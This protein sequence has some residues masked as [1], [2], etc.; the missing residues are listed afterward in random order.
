MKLS[1]SII[2]LLSILFLISVASPSTIDTITDSIIFTHVNTTNIN[3]VEANPTSWNTISTLPCARNASY[4]YLILINISLANY[5]ACNGSTGNVDYAGTWGDTMDYAIGTGNRYII[6]NLNQNISTNTRITVQNDTTIESMGQYWIQKA[7]TNPVF[8]ATNST[9]NVK[10]TGFKIDGKNTTVG[11]FVFNIGSHESLTIENNII[12]NVY[13]TAIN[14]ANSSGVYSNNVRIINNKMRSVFGGIGITSY[15]SLISGNYIT[16]GLKYSSNEEEYGEGI[17]S[18]SVSMNNI[19]ENNYVEGFGE[20]GIDTIG[21]IGGT[22]RGNTIKGNISETRDNHGIEVGT[23]IIVVENNITSA[24]NA[25]K[26]VGTDSIIKNNIIT[27]GDTEHHL[28]IHYSV[29]ESTTPSNISI[30]GNKIG[31]DG[32][33]S[34]CIDTRNMT[35]VIIKDNELGC[36]SGSIW[37]T[38]GINQT[39]TGNTVQKTIQLANMKNSV[40]SLNRVHGNLTGVTLQYLNTSITQNFGTSPYYFGN[41]VTAPTSFGTGDTYFNTTSNK[42]CYY[43][44][45]EWNTYADIGNC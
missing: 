21:N 39:I 34:Y 7:G 32:T 3:G 23:G 27:G 11:G 44:G 6:V 10:I 13:G 30:I 14:I 43:N 12:D 38:D 1:N 18:N 28:I 26:I 41:F 19:I 29:L 36:V 40:I 2:I 35:G 5:Q 37:A 16:Q 22:V 20:D 25:I 42:P 15:N 17:D 8:R 45:T 9:K 24:Q 33:G 4:D 31:M